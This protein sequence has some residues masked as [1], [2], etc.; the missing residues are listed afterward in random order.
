[1]SDDKV[2][3]GVHPSVRTAMNNHNFNLS[4]D[5]INI[6]RK[7]GN[8]WYVTRIDEIRLSSNST[9]KYVLLKPTS[10]M[11]NLIGIEREIVAI[12][13]SYSD[14][15]ARTLDSIKRVYEINSEY[16]LDKLCGIVISKDKNIIKIIENYSKRELESQVLIPYTFSEVLKGDTYLSRNKFKTY[17]FTRDL[18]A[19]E[20]PLKT[21]LYFFGRNDLIHSLLDRHNRNLNSGLFGLRKT[22]KTSIVFSIIRLLDS[23]ENTFAFIDCEDTGFHIKRWNEALH[24][25]ILELCKNNIGIN[26]L[27]SYEDYTPSNASLCFQ[28]DLKQIYSTTCNKKVLLIF[29]EI[30]NITFEKSPSAHWNDDND[31]VLFWQTIRSAYHKLNNV[32][33]F[34]IVGT[35]PICIERASIKLLDNPIFNMVH[36]DYI[37]GLSFDQTKDMVR[38]LGRIMGLRL[39]ETLYAKLIEDFGGHPFLIRQFCSYLNK[40]YITLERPIDVIRIQ[41]EKAKESFYDNNSQYVEMVLEVLKRFYRDEYDMLCFLAV[42]DYK[43]FNE[44]AKESTIYTNHLIGYGIITKS[45][46]E[47]D[48]RFDAIKSYLKMKNKYKKI[49]LTI[50]EKWNELCERR[51]NMEINLR[52]IV[53]MQLYAKYNNSAKEIILSIMESRRREKYKNKKLDELL[54]ANQSEIYLEDLRKIIIKEWNVF[55]NLFGSNQKEFESSMTFINKLGRSDTHAKD[56]N[57]DEIDLIR[58]CFSKIEKQ[59]LV[60]LGG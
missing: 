40:L 31:F 41:Y 29:D 43:I 24:Y 46:D 44:F 55:S 35:N 27:H 39:D 10:F 48:F 32:F 56:I 50:E 45:G 58:G 6:I 11:T 34:L 18:F 49:N 14:F 3:F 28:E 12:I 59:I 1:M 7:L 2:V 5:E 37:N 53:R 51:N 47:Y 54:N 38:T 19:Y 8:E 9:Q 4:E 60:F 25:V 52:K 21:D 13:S 16:R 23:N 36:V 22:G 57:D 26:N 15:D 33:T 20:S 42:G 30:E 17:F